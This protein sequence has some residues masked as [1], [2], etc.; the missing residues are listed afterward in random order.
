[1]SNVNMFE[2]ATRSKMRFPYKGQISVED[3]WDLSLPAL[4]SVFKA[5]NS[6][7]KQV[8]EESLLSTK[9]KADTILELQIEIVKYIVSVKLAEQEARE[10]AAEKS[11]QRQKIMEIMA[12]K[13]DESL[14][15]ASMEDLQRMLAELSE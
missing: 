2:V 8:K 6:Q 7:M 11:V 14:E 1:M 3:M 15:S 10:K 4:D 12:K 9:S 5:L 13:Q